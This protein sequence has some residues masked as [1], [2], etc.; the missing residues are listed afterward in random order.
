MAI[1][2]KGID[3]HTILVNTLCCSRMYSFTFC[4][5]FVLNSFYEINSLIYLIVIHSVCHLLIHPSQQINFLLNKNI[6]LWLPIQNLP[7]QNEY[8]LADISPEIRISG[9][10]NISILSL[11]LY[12]DLPL[13]NISLPGSRGMPQGI[14]GETVA[15]FVY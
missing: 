14:R 11:H 9:S 2:S 3:C 5:L 7:R 10:L 6:R 15:C 12:V 13:K 4:L 8:R 1:K